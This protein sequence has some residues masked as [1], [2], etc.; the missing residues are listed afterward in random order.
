M[1][2]PLRLLCLLLLVGLGACTS[3]EEQLAATR[4]ALDEVSPAVAEVPG[5]AAVDYLGPDPSTGTPSPTV[6]GGTLQLAADVDRDRAEQLLLEVAEVLWRSDVPVIESIYLTVVGDGLGGAN[7]L[8]LL[9]VV[10]DTDRAALE[11]RFG[12]RQ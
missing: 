4:A 9:E 3:G 5:V 8:S 10:D 2:P 11:E 12:P 7:S 6:V 1:R